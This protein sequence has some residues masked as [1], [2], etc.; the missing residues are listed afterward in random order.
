MGET[1]RILIIAGPN[2]A[3]K[4]TF[5]TEY[6]LA[7]ADC[8]TFVN[9]DLIASGLNPF[10][11][12]AVALRAGRLMLEMISEL[13]EKRET[14]AFETTLSGRLYLRLIPLWQEAGYRVELHFLYLNSATLAISR[15]MERVRVGGH[16]V[17]D[18]VVRRRYDRGWRNF[19]EIY[20]D[21]VDEWFV[22]DNSGTMPVILAH[23]VKE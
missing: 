13:T 23:G 19:Q 18:D 16:S 10:E 15:V 2:G 20:Q 8:R 7:E 4:T 21:L 1:P 11:P 17:P 12:S 14:F 3:G 5:A 6:L 9:A 22:Y